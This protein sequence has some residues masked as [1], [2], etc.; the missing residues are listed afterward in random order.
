M[1]CL[2]VILAGCPATPENHYFQFYCMDEK[3]L[4]CYQAL[5]KI[6]EECK[7]DIKSWGIKENNK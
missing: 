7:E 1:F 4:V 6:E 5:P 3:A 2:D